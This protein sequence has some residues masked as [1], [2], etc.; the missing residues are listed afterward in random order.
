MRHL[1]DTDAAEAEPAEDSAWSSADI[2]TG[3]GPY[4]ELG[5]AFRLFNQCLLSQKDL[6]LLY[7]GSLPLPRSISGSP[8]MENQGEG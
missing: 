7:R 1:T 5:F 3:V 6:R 2:T 8:V 4:G